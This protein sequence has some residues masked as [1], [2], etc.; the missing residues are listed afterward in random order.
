MADGAHD[1][2]QRAAQQAQRYLTRVGGDGGIAEQIS[3]GQW[4]DDLDAAGSRDL[5]T[6]LD[7]MGERV[8][9]TRA[10]SGLSRASEAGPLGGRLPIN[11]KERYYTGTVLPMLVASDGFAYLDRFLTLCGLSDVDVRPNLEGDQNF[12]L[13]TEYGF[14]ESVFTDHDKA[15]WPGPHQADTPDVVIAG[16]DW[17]V[18]VEAKMFHNPSGAD[19]EAQ[20]RR[21]AVVVD[22]WRSAL[23]LS[24]D[25]VRHVLL[26]PSRLA[27]R[28]GDLSYPIVTW[29]EVL[30]EYDVVGPRYWARVLATAL[31]Q[32]ENLES[33]R[34][35]TFRS[36]A[37][38]TL[39]GAEIVEAHA[40]GEA[41]FDAVGRS[42][43]LSGAK[44]KD[45]VSS[46]KWRTVRYE[47][48]S[49]GPANR[50]WFSLADFIAAT[51]AAA[52]R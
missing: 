11:R 45:D 8:R 26:L 30:A 21:Q 5:S 27:E 41:T 39:T 43:G 42:G 47:I 7:V 9:Y 17:L 28:V 3:N 40:S 1:A 50:N 20:M 37:D 51:T 25:R 6:L 22:T 14:A 18:A 34:E 52:D 2:L 32:H 23:G 19:L 29:E 15:A 46:G 48:R 31:S 36:N 38:D 35:L 13:L 44:F 24:D 33:A 12:Q 16:P 49:G 4:N 10:Q